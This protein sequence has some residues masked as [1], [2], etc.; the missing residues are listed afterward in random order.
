MKGKTNF[1]QN[2]T[3]TDETVVDNTAMGGATVDAGTLA[4]MAKQFGVEL[5]QARRAVVEEEFSADSDVYGKLA[6][7][8][9]KVAEHYSA[10]VPRLGK[11]AF[12]ILD[13]G[14]D[15]LLVTEKVGELLYV[16]PCSLRLEA[17]G[18]A[19]IYRSDEVTPSKEEIGNAY[20]V[21]NV[22][23]KTK[24]DELQKFD[25]ILVSSDWISAGNFIKMVAAQF[26]ITEKNVR[27]AGLS[28]VYQAKQ[29]LEA[30]VD[31][32]VLARQ[33]QLFV[34]NLVGRQSLDLGNKA[35]YKAASDYKG[36]KVF[37][38]VY[39]HADTVQ[40]NDVDLRGLPNF[41]PVQIVTKANRSAEGLN[42]LATAAQEQLSLVGGYL[43]LQMIPT[44]KY[45]NVLQA[46]GV[47]L[48]SPQAIN[49]TLQYRAFFVQS[50]GYLGNAGRERLNLTEFV[51]AAF[52]MV[53]LSIHN[54]WRDGF[55]PTDIHHGAV[56]A[57]YDV[58]ALGY[59]FP[60]GIAWEENPSE[61]HARINTNPAV[62]SKARHQELM[63]WTCLPTLGYATDCLQSG[64]WS[65]LYQLLAGHGE[66]I[67]ARDV[68]ERMLLQAAVNRTDGRI[69]EYYN[70]TQHGSIILGVSQSVPWGTYTD[71]NGQ[72]Q[73]IRR[74]W[75]YLSYLS[76]AG[77]D[78][79]EQEVQQ[80]MAKWSL[81]ME[82]SPILSQE[83]RDKLTVDAMSSM[84]DN[85]VQ[86]DRTIRIFWNP[87]FLQAGFK[88]SQDAG[89]NIETDVT[90]QISGETFVRGGYAQSDAV[91]GV[92]QVDILGSGF[93]NNNQRVFY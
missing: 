75:N 9:A 45:H 76:E 29:L 10:K 28:E 20:A 1:G 16:H 66:A 65:W 11:I 77:K 32:I 93:S 24:V 82:S 83:I 37:A 78:A 44:T 74:K 8:F 61:A 15:L 3:S 86:V 35:S 5:P 79:T 80:A 41:A 38:S 26:D 46:S 85:F 43:D 73:D 87:V 58:G 6:D 21:A 62:Y 89:L 64:E 49:K 72:L 2:S 17:P 36:S 47:D 4:E 88:A 90:K 22:L 40:Q 81:L 48:N 34:S 19:R 39:T 23:G 42:P 7:K 91:F 14:K 18:A 69:L 13:G 59:E 54:N 68:V 70:P 67:V 60:V 55:Y 12:K 84:V 27:I 25:R 51:G 56:D 63:S 57:S 33:L 31:N 53:T 92:G 30:D 52:N 71:S 50:G